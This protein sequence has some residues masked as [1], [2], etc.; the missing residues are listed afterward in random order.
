MRES[1]Y[2]DALEQITLENPAEPLLPLLKNGF[3]RVNVLYMRSAL[4]RLADRP[5]AEVIPG[6]NQPPDGDILKSIYREQQHLRGARN[7]ASN[8]FHNCQSD[9]ARADV[10]RQI[11]ALEGAIAENEKKI[12]HYQVHNE[13]PTEQTDEFVI[14][15]DPIEMMK[16]QSSIRAQISQVKRKLDLLADQQ[17]PDQKAIQKYEAK[18]LK[19]KLQKGYVETAIKSK[20]IQPG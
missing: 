1:T 10:S 6:Q 2:I 8:E 15:D 17:Q 12:A 7:K 13:L 16:S 20:S 4:K 19:L 14:P 9:E 18:L 5:P 3:S 11:L